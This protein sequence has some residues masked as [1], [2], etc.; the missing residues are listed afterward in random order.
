MSLAPLGT[1]EGDERTHPTRKASVLLPIHLISFET[2]LTH[3]CEKTKLSANLIYV[4]G[5][6]EGGHCHIATLNYTLIVQPAN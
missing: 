2:V 4:H 6:R 3:F 5:E 1:R